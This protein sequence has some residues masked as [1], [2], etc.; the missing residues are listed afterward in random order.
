MDWIVGLLVAMAV[1]GVSLSLRHFL[2]AMPPRKMR[3]P[4]EID[5]PLE[6]ISADRSKED[7]S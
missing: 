5:P 1:V 6:F 4:A 3:R 2:T 7:I